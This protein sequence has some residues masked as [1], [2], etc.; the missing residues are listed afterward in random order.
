LTRNLSIAEDDFEVQPV[1]TDRGGKGR[2]RKIFNQ[3]LQPLI[4]ELNAAVAA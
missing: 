4:E 1:F 2:A 3:Q